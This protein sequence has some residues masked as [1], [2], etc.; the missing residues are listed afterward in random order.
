MRFIDPSRGRHVSPARMVEREGTMRR[1]VVSYPRLRTRDPR[2]HESV[3]R[4]LI[5]Q[6]LAA[7]Q[8][9][10]YAADYDDSSSYRAPVYFVPDDTLLLDTAHAFGIRSEEDLFGGVVPFPFVGTKAIT[11]PLT[12]PDANAPTGWSPAF[13]QVVQGAVLRGYTAFSRD[14]AKRGAR[15]LFEHGPVRLKPSLELGGRGQVVAR[16]MTTLDEAL[17][18]LDAE[19]L[20]QCGVVLEQN[21]SD[22]T[23]YS[24]GQVKV[25]DLVASYVGTQKTVKDHDG[26]DAYGGSALIVARGDFAALLALGIDDASR[27]AIEQARVYDDA[28][29]SCFGGF[30][31]SR[32]NYDIVR[33]VDANGAPCGGVLEQSWRLGGASG[34]EIAALEAFRADA[35]VNAVHAECTESYDEDASPPVDAT[36]YF[37]GVDARAG[38]ITKYATVAPY[39]DS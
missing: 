8:G 12:S 39:A 14:D 28:A 6:R 21:L 18:E 7:L 16:D 35:G 26:R 17:N 5:A 29:R 22:A 24:V 27:R 1:V 9:Y 37:R 19:D 11:H 3:T 38:F 23:T 4:S 10:E 31:A 20:A 15:Q 25:G 32:R 34:A 13:S 36:V 30:F 2:G 33:G